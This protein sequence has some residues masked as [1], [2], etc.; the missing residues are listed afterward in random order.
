MSQDVFGH[1]FL[2]TYCLLMVKM[3]YFWRSR[4]LIWRTALPPNAEQ[5]CDSNIAGLF[6]FGVSIPNLRDLKMLSGKMDF[7]SGAWRSFYRIDKQPQ[8]NGH[9]S[10]LRKVERDP[11]RCNC[12]VV[13]QRHQLLVSQPRLRIQFR[14]IGYA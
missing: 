3:N 11:L 12:P 14:N 10:I 4:T 1:L 8:R 9:M 2:T 6:S 7:T 13:Q 5:P